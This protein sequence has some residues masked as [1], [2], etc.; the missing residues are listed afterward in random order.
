[1]VAISGVKLGLFTDKYGSIFEDGTAVWRTLRGA[2]ATSSDQAD[3]QQTKPK[4][5]QTSTQ[6]LTDR[7]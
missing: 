7:F 6:K 1:M 4:S 5:A 2:G 3:E